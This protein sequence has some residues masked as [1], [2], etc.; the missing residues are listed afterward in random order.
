M[1]V[2]MG[3]PHP[4]VSVVLPFYNAP[5][6]EEAIKSI[7]NQSYSNYELLLIDN[8]STDGSSLVAQ[9]YAE[10]SKVTL[11]KE[12]RK[13][14]VFAANK[15]IRIA[16]G[17]WIAR[18]DADDIADSDRLKNQLDVLMREPALGVVSG[19]VTYLGSDENKG[20]I[21]YVEW[22]NTIQSNEEIRKNQFVEFPLANPTLIFKRELFNQFGFYEDGNFPEDYEFFLRLQAVGVQMKK[23]DKIVLKWRDTPSRL[24]RTDV[25]YSSDAFFRVKAKYLANWLKENNPFH[26]E[27]YLWGGGRRS[28]RRS[29]HL[30]LEGIEVVKHIDIKPGPNM[31][32]FEQIPEK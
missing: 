3:N 9:S 24:T 8:G 7:L 23:V 21:H 29:D 13:G 27:V 26:P 31:L 20:F 1:R 4:L 19:L 14:V 6:L 10:N 2:E 12:E 25:R 17:N 28:R 18:M 15:G 16:K 11:I 22:L 30:L 32:H 5:F